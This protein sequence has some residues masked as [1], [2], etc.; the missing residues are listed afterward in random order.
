MIFKD[1]QL[2]NDLINIGLTKEAQE[3]PVV[4]NPV[5]RELA[6]SLKE[7]LL[8][9]KQVDAEAY[10]AS[11]NGGTVNLNVND[12]RNLGDL[13]RW[14]ASNGITFKG[15]ELAIPGTQP[16]PG[17]GWL[18]IDAAT[19]D[20]NRDDNSQVIKEPFWINIESLKESLVVLRDIAFKQNN[21]VFKAMIGQAI[22]SFNSQSNLKGSSVISPKSDLSDQERNLSEDQMLESENDYIIDA[23]NFTTFETKD[24]S[25]DGIDEVVSSILQ[26]KPLVLE[27][28]SHKIRIKD[29]LKPG[30]FISFIQREKI[31]PTDKFNGTALEVKDSQYCV[32]FQNFYLRAKLLSR[33]FTSDSSNKSM[34][35]A[36]AATKLYLKTLE[37]CI[38]MI[39]SCPIPESQITGLSKNQPKTDVAAPPGGSQNVV[40]PKVVNG[41]DPASIARLTASL[42]NVGD[43]LSFNT[44]DL[45]KIYK[46][47][48]WLYTLN[49]GNSLG[50]LGLEIQKTIQKLNEYKNNLRLGASNILNITNFFGKTNEK[51]FFN[52]LFEAGV[53]TYKTISSINNTYV[54]P[55]MST[56]A[57]LISSVVSAFVVMQ[58]TEGLSSEAYKYIEKQ[59]GNAGSDGPAFQNV[60]RIQ[61]L[62]DQMQDFALKAQQNSMRNF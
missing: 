11:K 47:S 39:S 8:S 24:V 27:G 19:F 36:A 34:K 55:F 3:Q 52:R 28:K 54:Q 4:P 26:N 38:K 21:V 48:S 56:L 43:I 45:D 13:V 18:I 6:N 17:Q 35:L 20:R 32:I 23:F 25:T 60:R 50:E 22:N 30:D 31:M 51:E 10:F 40:K 49:E 53:G 46:F 37:S 29:I 16:S 57:D 5:V 42:M 44:V 7:K 15:K 12:L 58:R 2:I 41:I 33:S 14:F 62:K 59:I 9:Q 1:Q 61:A